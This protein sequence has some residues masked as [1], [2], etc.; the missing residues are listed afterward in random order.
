[1]SQHIKEGIKKEDLYVKYGEQIMGLTNESLENLT[2]ILIEKY[3]NYAKGI[4][5]GY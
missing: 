1:M 4:L 5:Y 2:E 3:T